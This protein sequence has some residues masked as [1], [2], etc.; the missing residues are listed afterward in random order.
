[1]ITI[2]IFGIYIQE[3]MAS[4][5][6]LLVSVVCF[7]AFLKIHKTGRKEKAFTFFKLY[8][9]L[10]S[11]STLLGGLLGHAFMYYMD[12]AWKLPG[13]LVSMFAIMFVERASIEH[14]GTLL[15]PRIVK[16]FKIVNTLELAL[17]V[18]LT[19]YFLDFFY[20]E[21]HSGYGIMFVVL[22]LQGYLYFKNRNEASKNILI[23]VGVAAIAAL[24]FMNKVSIHPWF[25]HLAMS[26]TIMSV[27][28]FF[29]YRGVIKIELYNKPDGNQ[30]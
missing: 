20:V 23:G 5:T 21:F 13:W 24:I 8:F 2:E 25:N 15:P 29:F 28:A 26:H 11:I 19:F 3:P 6:D 9:F 17:F 18:F 27:S 22:S 4:L 7:L 12:F 16:A 1:M 14:S 30:S 10:M